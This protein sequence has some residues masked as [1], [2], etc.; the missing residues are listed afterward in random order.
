MVSAFWNKAISIR[1][2]FLIVASF[3]SLLV[4]EAY[5]CIYICTIYIVQ[6]LKENTYY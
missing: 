5:I 3:P 1:T 4:K 6:I 2:N